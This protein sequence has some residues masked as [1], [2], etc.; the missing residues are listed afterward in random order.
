MMTC[1]EEKDNEKCDHN[2]KTEIKSLLILPLVSGEAPCL[3]L[4][5]ADTDS[6]ARLVFFTKNRNL[7]GNGEI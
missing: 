6:L 5:D 1:W 4:I 3:S 2:L 7:K